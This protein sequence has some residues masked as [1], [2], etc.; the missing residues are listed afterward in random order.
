[1]KKINYQG[2]DGYFFTEEEYKSIIG[3]TET[4]NNLL[5]EIGDVTD[6]R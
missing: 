4:I 6:G 1:M 3:R 5:Q 2:E